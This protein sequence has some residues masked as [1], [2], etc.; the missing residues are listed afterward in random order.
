MARLHLAA[1]AFSLH[2]APQVGGAIAQFDRAGR[3]ILR[4][5][6]EDETSVLA[7]GSFPLVPYV[8]RI[9]GG[10]FECDGQT[11]ILSP[12]MA[13]DASP[14]HGQG[15]L[16]EWTVVD[17]DEQSAVLAFR[18]EPGEWPW[19]YDSVQRFL[20][21]EEGLTQVLTCRNLSD[22]RMPCGL[23]VHPY[24]PCDAKTV[25]DTEVEGAWTVDADVLPVSHVPAEGRFDLR[26]R[27]VCGQGLDNGF[28]GWNGRTELAWTDGARCTMSSTDARFFQL[29]SPETGGLFVAEPVQHANAA[30]NAPQ[31]EWERLGIALLAP[32]ESRT[33]TVRFEA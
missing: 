15:W 28:D 20:L 32:G 26:Q 3:P 25:L 21:D 18:H 16:A 9:R 27:L 4:P 22:R 5:A 1:G 30:L 29:Y 23:G 10:Q 14:L 2:L 13:G 8:N 6:G 24:F 31:E 11:V 33:L 12:N 17:A 7:M 19:R